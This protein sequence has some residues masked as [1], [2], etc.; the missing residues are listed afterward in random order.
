MTWREVSSTFWA[1]LP[2]LFNSGMDRLKMYILNYELP[3][4]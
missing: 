4:Y 2:N 3:V 1:D